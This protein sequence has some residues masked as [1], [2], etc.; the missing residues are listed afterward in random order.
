MAATVDHRS[1]FAIAIAGLLGL[2][3]A[4]AALN[5]VLDP[6]IQAFIP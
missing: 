3:I 5:G 1:T 6:A 4:V 2:V